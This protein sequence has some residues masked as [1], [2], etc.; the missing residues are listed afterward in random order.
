MFSNQGYGSNDAVILLEEIKEQLN[1]LEANLKEDR[2]KTE[3]A[4]GELKE[5]L[6]QRLELEPEPKELNRSLE[7]KANISGLGRLLESLP[8]NLLNNLPDLGPLLEN[9][10][11]LLNS[12]LMKLLPLLANDKLTQTLDVFQKIQERKLPAPSEILPI[13][14]TFVPR[15]AGE[16]S[17]LAEAN[18]KIQ[19]LRTMQKDLS[20]S[21]SEFER[22]IEKI[23]AM[24][25][26]ATA[27]LEIVELLI[28]RKQQVL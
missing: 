6:K 2:L 10:Q 21:N 11:R 9:P 20:R 17:I 22:T 28:V 19:K 3:Q 26:E 5:K 23:H 14:Q 27:L 18:P 15:P 24:N 25:K 16:I 8:S 7:E 1:R 4:I 13:V 12:P